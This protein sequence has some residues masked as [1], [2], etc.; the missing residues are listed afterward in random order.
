[1]WKEKDY[2]FKGERVSF[3]DQLKT[4]IIKALRVIILLLSGNMNTLFNSIESWN[5][6]RRDYAI[7]ERI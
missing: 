4:L 1:M 7:L 5:T 3:E 2:H 6:R